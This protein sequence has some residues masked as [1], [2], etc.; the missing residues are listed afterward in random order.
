[1]IAFDTSFLTM[2]FVPDAKH[3]IR[4]ARA[5]IN[6]LVS[7]IHATGERILVPTPVLSELLVQSG[8]AREQI[9]AELTKSP[10]FLLAA[11]DIPCALELALMTDAAFTS[12]D[13]KSGATGPYIKVKFDRQI[14]ATAKA[15][16]ARIMYSDDG[17]IRAICAREELKCDGVADIKLPEKNLNVFDWGQ[18]LEEK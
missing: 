3:E 17:D 7:E 8:D 4:D 11:F 16:G 6:F 2:L 10:K 9:I 15:H 5:R 13:K 1:M 18:P 14:V 12:K